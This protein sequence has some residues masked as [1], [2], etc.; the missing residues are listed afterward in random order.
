MLDE[1]PLKPRTPGRRQRPDVLDKVAVLMPA[2]PMS[3]YVG[4]VPGDNTVF[5]YYVVIPG[6]LTDV[7]FILETAQEDLVASVE[8]QIPGRLTTTEIPLAN[9]TTVIEEP[10]IVAKGMYLTVRLKTVSGVPPVASDI[11]VAACFKPELS[12]NIAQG[13]RGE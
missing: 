2:V 4:G 7:T 13:R 10:I 9:G 11:W 5:R 3:F 1:R 12:G 8:T 6:T